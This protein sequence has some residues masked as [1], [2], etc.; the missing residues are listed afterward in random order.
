LKVSTTATWT[1][2]WDNMN[3][4]VGVKQVT[5]TGTQLSVSYS[6]DVLN[7]RVEDDTWKPGTGTLTVRHAF[8]GNNIWADVTTTN[9][10]LARYVYG[11]GVDQVWARAIPSGLTNAGVAWYLTDRQGSVRDIMDNTGTIQ[12]HID[13]DGYGNATHTTVSFADRQGYAG[14]QTDLNPG[15]VQQRGRWYE[16][17]I[18]RWMSEDPIGFG[19][20]DT[21]LQRYVGNDPTNAVDPSGCEAVTIN[22]VSLDQ[23]ITQERE[24]VPEAVNQIQSIIYGAGGTIDITN[25]KT[26]LAGFKKDEVLLFGEDRPVLETVRAGFVY[27]VRFRAD[28]SKL[29]PAQRKDAVLMQ[30]YVFTARDGTK[31]SFVERFPIDATG[32]AKVI[33]VHSWFSSTVGSRFKSGTAGQVSFESI[34]GLGKYK[35]DQ[36]PIIDKAGYAQWKGTVD[37]IEWLKPA[38]TKKYKVVFKYLPPGPTD[39]CSHGAVDLT[40]SGSD[41]GAS[42]GVKAQR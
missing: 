36:T 10:L 13:Y 38:E 30:A 5:T 27:G 9:T 24:L 41:L 2:G 18:G 15:L 17:P 7:N 37:D 16:P 19:G 40:D 23:V 29:T 28:I 26:D 12:D 34:I 25:P 21:N 31:K 42:V 6:Y 33:D 22:L 35:G 8:D 1:Y 14:G 4:L 20:E 3:Q 11:D 32:T 39:K